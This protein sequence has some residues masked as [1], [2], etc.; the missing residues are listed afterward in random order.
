MG[1]KT[2]ETTFLRKRREIICIAENN[3]QSVGLPIEAGMGSTSELVE[4]IKSFGKGLPFPLLNRKKKDSWKMCHEVWQH[5]L[6]WFA[7]DK[8]SFL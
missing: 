6:M 2:M 8:G 3:F 7:T 4:N 5:N 1:I